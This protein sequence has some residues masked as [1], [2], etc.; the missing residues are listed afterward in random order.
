MIMNHVEGDKNYY[1]P[2]LRT[3]PVFGGIAGI[4]STTEVPATSADAA[5]KDPSSAIP[6][7]SSK[8]RDAGEMQD[9]YRRTLAASWVAQ[10]GELRADDCIED[11]FCGGDGWGSH[12]HAPNNHVKI[13]SSSAG[14]DVD[15]HDQLGT[16]S[17]SRAGSSS[18]TPGDAN[19][20]RAPSQRSQRSKSPGRFFGGGKSSHKHNKSA[21]SFTSTRTATSTNSP[22]AKK[23]G[24]NWNAPSTG[25][26]GHRGVF[27][28]RTSLHQQV[29]R[30]EME[31]IKRASRGSKH[32]E[33]N[34]N[35]VD[36][37]DNDF[38]TD[39]RAW[40]VG[41]QQQAE[42]QPVGA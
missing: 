6:S 16:D 27:G 26:P 36:E 9:M 19:L 34:T 37:F 17:R 29:R 8:S 1:A 12:L 2:P 10:P 7:L 3:A 33:K 42:G 22:S 18:L 13:S 21:T 40:Q 39:L 4:M 23:A 38:R 14:E 41:S 28:G 15:G 25:A 11:I 30:L 35:E 20:Q 31:S 24:A 32:E 5:D